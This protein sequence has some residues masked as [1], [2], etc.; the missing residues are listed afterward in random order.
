MANEKTYAKG[1]FAEKKTTT[2]GEI[3]KVSFK[4][5][6]FI[7]FLNEHKNEK[8]YVNVDILN[9]KEEGKLYGVLNDYKPQG[10]VGGGSG[11]LPF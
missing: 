8:G 10:I 5:D 7:Q 1:L 11:N 2:F 4:A 3:T 9:A 6:D